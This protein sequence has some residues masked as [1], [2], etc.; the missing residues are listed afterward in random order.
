MDFEYF[1]KFQK[2]SDYSFCNYDIV[3][4]IFFADYY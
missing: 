2:F 1:L 3:L 4:N